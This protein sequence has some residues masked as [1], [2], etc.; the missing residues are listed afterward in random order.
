MA[1]EL[2]MLGAAHAAANPLTARHGV[3]H[4]HAVALMLPHVVRFN[5]ADPAVA[6][7]YRV[8]APEVVPDKAPERLPA[9]ELVDALALGL[10]RLMDQARLPRSLRALGLRENQ[11]AALAA[12]AAG[13]WTAG[14]NPRPVGAADFERLYRLAWGA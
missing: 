2:S 13:Q 12:D 7:A 9:A 14:F 5:G 10:E 4:G 3:V 6:E 1:I 8:V 11:L